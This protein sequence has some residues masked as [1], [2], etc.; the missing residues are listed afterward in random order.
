MVAGLIGVLVADVGLIPSKISA[1]GIEFTGIEQSN[2]LKL[3]FVIVVYY[4]LTFVIY[5]ISELSASK[6]LEYNEHLDS[7]SDQIKNDV[8]VNL[9]NSNLCEQRDFQELKSSALSFCRSS[10]EVALPL[11][12]GCYA[13]Y[14]IFQVM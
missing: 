12:W 3:L 10:Y 6:L 8:L 1:L 14:A 9:L 5:A 4:V 7:A 2:L 13:A 11:V